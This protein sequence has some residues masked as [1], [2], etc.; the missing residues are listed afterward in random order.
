[1]PN[2]M[3]TFKIVLF[4]F[5]IFQ[6]AL[7]SGQLHPTGLLYSDP[8]LNPEITPVFSISLDRGKSL[9][10]SVDLSSQMPPI[11]DQGGQYSCVAW[12]LGY[13]HKTHTEWREQGWNV[14]LPQNQFSPA[15][16]YNHINGGVDR[17]SYFGD[18]MKVITNHGVA[19]MVLCP[20]DQSDYTTWP[21]EIAYSWAIPYRGDGA[22]WID[23]RSDTGL[24][25]IKTQL[26]NGYTVVL[27][28]W[29][30]SNFDDINS[31]DT[32]YCIAD[33]YGNNRGGH[34]VTFVG[35][36]DN[37]ATHDGVGA[38]KL[39]NSWGTGWGNAG[40]FWMSYQAVKDEYLSYREAY[41]VTDRI[42][43]NP[44]LQACIRITHAGRTFVVIRFGFGPTSAPRGTMDF[45]NWMTK[46]YH[47]FPNNNMVFDL[48]DSIFSLGPDSLV[49]LRCVDNG[50]DGITGTINFFSSELVGQFSNISS[51]PPVAIPDFNIPAY[52]ILSMKAG[53]PH[54][55]IPFSPANGCTVNALRPTLWVRPI[56]AIQYHFRVY[57]ADSLVVEGYSNSNSWTVNVELEDGAV[58]EWDCRA[59]NTDGWS[60]YFSP[61]WEFTVSVLPQITL[62]PTSFNLALPYNNITDT[63]LTI[64]NSGGVGGAGLNWSLAEVPLVD[65]LSENPTSG[66]IAPGNQTNITM[67]FNTMGLNPGTYRCTLSISSNDP[68]NPIVNVPVEL[69]V[70]I[71]VNW[72][73]ATP[74]AGW[75]GRLQHTSVVFDNKI[76]VLGGVDPS[77]FRNDIWY[78]T[79]GVNWTQ[80]TASA[81]WSGRWGHTSVVFDNKMW[82]MGGNDASDTKNDV[83]YSSDGVNWTQAT[84]SA[85]WSGRWG[86][87]SV[88]FDNKMWVMGGYDRN[89]VWY[90]TDGVNW[91]CAT[92]SAGWSARYGHT[93]VVFDNKIWVLGGYGGGL[94]RD[95]WYSTDG[96]N[97]ETQTSSVAWS[98]RHGHTLVVFDNK[99]WVFGG[100]SLIGS[101][102]DVWYSTDGVNWI[103][104]TPSAGW[105]AR[106]GHTSVVFDNKIWVLGG[107]YSIYYYNDVWYSE[108]ATN[109]I[110]E[111]SEENV[112]TT[113]WLKQNY[114]NPFNSTTT[115]EYYIPISTHVLLKV[116]DLLGRKVAT[117]VNEKKTIGV[118]KAVFNAT[119]LPTGVYFCRLQAGNYVE[120]RKLLLL[121]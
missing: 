106:H 25:L 99:I 77:G 60:P 89:D 6:S 56:S 85:G 83:W 96:V 64:G 86:H 36:D 39:V 68:V 47:P 8:R 4:L 52:A 16:I 76:W 40:Y 59:Q 121:K 18:A 3:K 38:F 79:D 32:T 71:G 116:F 88:V 2:T 5:L 42:G 62:D 101:R 35:Y 118:H 30:W 67:S 43:Y 22:Y 110:W 46:A 50:D 95:A 73:C 90:S 94:R 12:A 37:R 9:L 111:N 65:W 87:T 13:Y 20:Y 51:D 80:A 69:I 115:I 45:F 41:Y 93:S 105:S 104:A 82:V 61:R 98:A 63:T 10:P 91:I 102:N 109:S 54:A 97:W 19:N 28:I 17:G 100:Y 113:F 33:R 119:S 81:G 84:A 48:T 29:V 55:P 57:R 11:G 75:S 44:S 27:G 66:A 112:P 70:G 120:T 78:S 49:F 23:C 72:I 24:N 103:C 34:A 92:P 114:P 1:L 53:P 107:N 7:A 74:S 31:F 108:V 15:F 117:L 26:A 14:N 21:S 58:Y